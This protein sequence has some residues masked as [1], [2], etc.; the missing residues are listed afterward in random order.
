MAELM[1]SVKTINSAVRTVIAAGLLGV[2]G[3][4]GYFGYENY[5]K[6]GMQAKQ[7]LADLEALEQEFVAQQ[8]VLAETTANLEQAR[9]ENEKLATSLKLL[10]VDRRMANVEILELGTDEE[11]RP[12]M[13]VRFTEIDRAGNPVGASRDF[14]LSGDRLYIDCWIVSFDD[15][16][17]EEADLLRATSLCVFK[18]IYGD[19]DGPRNAHSLDAQS[20]SAG[21]PGIYRDE[22]QNTFEEKIWGDF[23]NVCNDVEKQRELGIRASYGQANYVRVEEGKVYQVQLR[24]SGGASIHPIEIANTR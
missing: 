10:K 24:A 12:E 22:E 1:T 21:A 13:L 9:I 5:V 17:V 18:S 7:A 14:T 8:K 6:P 11:G 2:V 15:K 19:I 20:V 4:G 16:Y 23:W 3:Y